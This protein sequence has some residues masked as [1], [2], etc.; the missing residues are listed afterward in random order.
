MTQDDVTFDLAAWIVQSDVEAGG[1]TQFPE[2][3]LEFT[4][5]KGAALVFASLDRDG[6]PLQTSLHW[7]R[8][9]MSGE[10]WIATKWLRTGP[11]PV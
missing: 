1:G 4:P 7:G 6:A 5:L 11:H 9:V 10:K 8:P 2:L 3:S